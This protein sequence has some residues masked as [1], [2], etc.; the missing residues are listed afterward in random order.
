MDS[1][2]E[3]LKKI[4]Y[5]KAR[6]MQEVKYLILLNRKCPP[7]SIDNLVV[8]IQMTRNMKDPEHHVHITTFFKNTPPSVFLLRTEAAM[9]CFLKRILHTVMTDMSNHGEKSL[10]SWYSQGKY[11][12]SSNLFNDN[13]QGLLRGQK[14][15]GSFDTYS[16][17]KGKDDQRMLVD[18]IMSEVLLLVSCV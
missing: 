1:L 13:G 3:D 8:F 14:W 10:S 17:V 16:W 15:S 2:S 4:I 12:D 6:V 11:T 9:R 7:T 5:E 18:E